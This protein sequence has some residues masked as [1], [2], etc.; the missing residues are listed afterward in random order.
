MHDGAQLREDR[1]DIA[2][3][4]IQ[5]APPIAAGAA[6]APAL[7]QDRL[8][9]P[10][11]ND[12]LRRLTATVRTIRAADGRHYAAVSVDG[13]VEYYR[14]AS[15]EFRRW[16]LRQYNDATGSVPRQAAV[17]HFVATLLGRAEIKSN[18][19][20]VFV[21]VA[22][23]ED[24]ASLIDLGDAGRQAVRVCAQGWEIAGHPGVPFWRPPGQRAF[25]TPARG[26]SIELLKKYAN[27]SAREWPLLL[28]WLTAA[29]RPEGPYPVLVL[30][31]EQG[32]AKS[33]LAQ[34]CRRLVDPHAT[35]LRSLPRSE[36]DLMVSAHNNWLLA[37]DNISTLTAWQSDALCRLSTGGGFAARELFT[38]D[39]ELVINAQRPIIL[40]GIDDFVSRG[41]LIDRSIFVSLPRIVPA[42]RRGDQSFW[43]EFDGDYPALFGAV[44]D[45]VAGGLR[46]WRDVEL[47][48][49]SR[50]A[51]LDRWGEAVARGL[52]WPPG[53]FLAAYYANRRSACA[54]ALEQVPLAAALNAMLTRGGAVECTPTQLLGVLN[55]FRPKRMSA[56]PGWPKSPWALSKTLRRLAA[57]LRT[58]G[59][60]V[61]FARRYDARIIRIASTC[62]DVRKMRS[63]A[64]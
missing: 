11:E 2:Q 15:D 27:L 25:P 56:A 7:P 19:E 1:S 5:I 59:I 61:T 13:Q 20:S 6:P 60:V 35:L 62:V 64:M 46:F 49:L 42:R 28:G 26:G 21:R 51:D 32:S 41:D 52:G 47:S 23:D 14:L 44:L 48:T 8:D 3:A 40:N 33:T 29:L 38:D 18:V 55:N 4:D 37:Y 22:R 63:P 58:I 31:G 36:R 45:A 17:A 50:M 24:D 9:A 54:W 39:R 53:T 30:T 43:A 10:G 16:L 34:V 57:Q 12:L